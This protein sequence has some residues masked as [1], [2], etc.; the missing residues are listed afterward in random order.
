MAQDVTLQAD[1]LLRPLQ[2]PAQ[3]LSLGSLALDLALSPSTL[4]PDLP[5]AGS[6]Y[7][8]DRG[9]HRE[10]NGRLSSCSVPTASGHGTRR[11]VRT[12]HRTRASPKR[13]E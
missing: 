10:R 13:H 2:L 3:T 11:G 8:T 9:G 7:E 5:C 12:R 1:R 6:A 4:E